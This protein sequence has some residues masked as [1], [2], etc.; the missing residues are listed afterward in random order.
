MRNFT[1]IAGAVFLAAQV[2]A[3]TPERLDDPEALRRS[4]KRLAE[5]E[6]W[7]KFATPEQIRLYEGPEKVWPEIPADQYDLAGFDASILGGK[8]PAA[9]VH[10][11]VL[12]NQEDL[13]AIREKILGTPAGQREFALTEHILRHTMLDP[14]RSDGKA[15]AKLAGGDRE[16]L[17]FGDPSQGAGGH[18]V[19]EGYKAEIYGAHVCYWPRN[20]A[21]LAFYALVKDDAEL[22]RRTAVAVY[23]YY[24][25]REPLIDAQNARGKDPNAENAWPSDLWR[26]MH[27]VAGEA[28]LGIAYDLTATYMTEEQRT[29]LR[30]VIAKATAGKRSYSANGPLRWRDTNWTGWDTQQ[31]LC[32]LAIEG[33]DGY[34]PAVYAAERDTVRAYLTYG[35]TPYGTIFETNGKNGAGI[36]FALTSAIALAR[37]GDNYLGHPYLRKMAASQVHQVVPAGGRNVSNG[38]YGCALFGNAGFLK[39]LYP[40]DLA[41][42][43]LL[44]QGRPLDEDEQGLDLA[45]YREKL[46]ANPI[47]WHRLHPLTADT[48]FGFAAYAGAKNADGKPK[49]TWQRDDLHLPLDFEDPQHGQLCT[50]SS[51]DKDALFLMIEAR[52]DLYCGGHQHHDAGHFYLSAHGVAWG[53]ESDNGLRES[54]VHSVVMIDGKGQGDA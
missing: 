51:N 46:N 9:G 22:S 6:P 2:Q 26:G 43:W 18:H 1:I 3:D 7:T 34:D 44:R 42:D 13:P 38:T 4:V 37:R 27:L 24:K 15:F 20:L 45:A 16:G 35:I 36:H 29:L 31:L 39:N 49:A 41:A 12:F 30:R 53:I 32:H 50:R 10:P 25:L 21:A 5:Q 23:N 47:N 33:E 48:Y 17:K 40:H 28:H 11:R 52:P 14:S 8:P 54:A 19:F